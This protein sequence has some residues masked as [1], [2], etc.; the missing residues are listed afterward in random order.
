M[1]SKLACVVF[2]GM[3][4]TV[5]G[6]SYKKDI[7]A[8]DDC[9]GVVISYTDQIRL[10]FENTCAVPDC[11]NATSTNIGGPFTTYALIRN[12]SLKIK[13]QVVSGIMPQ[14]SSLTAT[15]IKAIRCWVDSG[16]PEN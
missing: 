5:S 10:I 11:H 14:G 2:F 8:T 9:S 1:I 13:Q 7:P 16:A 15:Q 4:I 6:C 3:L 12:K